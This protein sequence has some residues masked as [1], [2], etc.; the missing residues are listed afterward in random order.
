[1]N[2]FAPTTARCAAGLA[3]LPVMLGTRD[4]RPLGRRSAK[5]EVENLG[6]AIEKLD[7]DG[8]VRNG[9]RLADQL[10][11]PGFARSPD[12][13]LVYVKPMRGSWRCAV[14]SDPESDGAALLRCTHDEIYIARVKP[15]YDPPTGPVE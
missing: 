14:N 3:L 13:L 12:T 7:V 2:A 4:P 10:I 5:R 6:G 1:M 9:I 11:H 15:V 8:P